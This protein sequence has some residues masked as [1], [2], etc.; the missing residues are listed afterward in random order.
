MNVVFLVYRLDDNSIEF[1]TDNIDKAVRYCVDN[2]DA[3]DEQVF[4]YKTF[5]V[6]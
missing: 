2:K 5:K 3:N 6:E 1:V 4:M